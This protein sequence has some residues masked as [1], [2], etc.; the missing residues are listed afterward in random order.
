[1]METPMQVIFVGVVIAAYVIQWGA[2]IAAVF[3]HAQAKASDDARPL[4]WPQLPAWL[5]KRPPPE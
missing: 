3:D 1:M 2:A 5:K 4:V